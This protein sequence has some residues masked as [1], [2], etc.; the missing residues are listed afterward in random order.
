MVA[1][2]DSTARVAA[3]S[4][5]AM[6]LS[7]AREIPRLS[8]LTKQGRWVR[9]VFHELPGRRLGL[10]GFGPVA[11]QVSDLARA[12]GLEC[13]VCDSNA[14]EDGAERDGVRFVGRDELFRTSHYL[15]LVD[16]SAPFTA[17]TADD[18]AQL[19]EGAIL[20]ATVPDALPVSAVEAAL[21]NGALAGVGFCLTEAEPDHPLTRFDNVVVLPAPGGRFEG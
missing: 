4:A 8:N 16:A 18:L 21:G 6:L 14:D 13:V 5:L 12:F 7:L 2:T 11:R 20:V 1:A 19:P 15:A 9:T 10:V 17:L 3:E